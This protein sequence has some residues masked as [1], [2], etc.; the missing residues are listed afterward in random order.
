MKGGLFRAPGL[1]LLLSLAGCGRG[2]AEG[3]PQIRYGSEVCQECRMLITEERFA[4]AVRTEKGDFEKF[5]D[6]GCLIRYETEKGRGEKRWVRSFNT[7]GW[8]DLDQAVVAR[9]PDLAT[10]M[11][12]GL[13]AFATREE[14]EEFLSEW[15]GQIIGV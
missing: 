10:P 8:L 2:T 11:G 7:A 4:A 1:V 5:D 13:A 6:L 12:S 14:A 9:S 3:P 15:K